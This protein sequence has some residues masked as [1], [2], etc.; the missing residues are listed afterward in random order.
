MN[1]QKEKTNEQK[2]KMNEQRKER[3]QKKILDQTYSITMG[4]L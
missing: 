1:E 4:V 3:N 2:E